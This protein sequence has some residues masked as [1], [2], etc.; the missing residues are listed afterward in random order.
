VPVSE[1]FMQNLPETYWSL[2]IE[3]GWVQSAIW[4]IDSE[5]KKAKVLAVSTASHWESD[6]DL[7]ASS[8]SVLSGAASELSDESSEPSKT[9]F[10][11]PASWVEGGQIREDHIDKIR[12]VC[13][14]L[15]LEPSGFVVLPEAIAYFVKS[16]EGAPLNGI[17][18]GIGSENL[19]ISV[20][21][22][23]N[24]IGNVTVARS[25]S[26]AEDVIEG[27][28][29]FK[30]SDNL[31]SRILIFDGKE[32]QLE[33]ARQLLVGVDW[34]SPEVSEK[35]KFLHIPKVE[36]IEP[37]EK[38]L[39]V[40]LAGASEIGQANTVFF[41]GRRDDE[42]V[43]EEATAQV[44]KNFEESD[45]SPEELGFVSGADI[46]NTPHE[47]SQVVGQPIYQDER[48][49]PVAGTGGVHLP[50]MP[51]IKLPRFRFPSLAF[52]KF[53]RF[54]GSRNG[55]FAGL[56][57]LG[58]AV[59]AGILALIL[60]PKAT[61]TVYVSPKKV[62][63]TQELT[64]GGDVE[65]KKETETVSGNKTV[66][67]T[68]TKTVGDRAKG[69]VT[70]YN[71]AD[72][73]TLSAGTKITDPSGLVFT[74]D[75]DT[76][77]A[78]GSGLLNLGTS[79]AAVSASDIGSQFN[80]AGGSSFTVNGYA[81]NELTAK[82][83][84]SFSG[85]SSRD[86]TA[87]SAED[88]KK[89]EDSLA[90]QLTDDGIAKIKEKLGTENILIEDSVAATSS[91]KEFNHKVGDEASDLNLSMDMEVTGLSVSKDALTKIAMNA[92]KDKILSGFVLRAN[93]ITT[94]F[95]LVSG[96]KYKVKFTANLLP[97]IKTDEVVKKI[98]G[99]SP[100]EAE[101]L[102]S[103]IAG[104]TRSEIKLSIRLGPFSSLPY[105]AKNITV[106]VSSEK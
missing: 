67:V 28:V 105:L 43:Q 86:I 36:I 12:K 52:L 20:F 61:V 58:L 26:I 19:E 94:D 64:I 18:I 90:S 62:D 54:T 74:L 11:V 78:S 81:S 53:P 104:Y 2:V 65:S 68:G 27:L 15:S 66:S 1:E 37:R 42:E 71:A 21:K 7:I 41:A 59:V 83:D 22:L 10:G 70:I 82:N 25:V 34:M 92:L 101:K 30:L 4:E 33:E 39:A 5:E 87:V 98:V 23:G 48:Q 13:S 3:S 51:D 100:T 49:Y 95:T 102:L 6:E 84:N 80:L 8:D 97:E 14:S 73:V 24:L 38:V 88:R 76:E 72:S 93:Q 91:G 99:K 96:K 77:V 103:A 35:I 63:S 32:G 16:N 55:L 46:R 89:A 79:T 44:E 9:V 45:V 57:L 69:Q 60:L 106:E 17:I 85:G 31:P 40:C 50:K 29:R 56:G 47:Q 75:N